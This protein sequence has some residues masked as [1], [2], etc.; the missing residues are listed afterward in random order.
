MLKK[1]IMLAL[2]NMCDHE[3]LHAILKIT[4]IYI[5]NTKMTLNCY[6]CRVSKTFEVMCTY[7]LAYYLGM[8]TLWFIIN[9]SH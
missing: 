1:N 8:E 5:Y 9:M 3:I 2:L 6:I 4:W 7:E